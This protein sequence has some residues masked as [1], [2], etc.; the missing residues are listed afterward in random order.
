MPR[1]R[2]ILKRVKKLEIKTNK[3]VEGIISGN[4][5]SVFKG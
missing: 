1:V 4:Y 5:H 3:L 2:E